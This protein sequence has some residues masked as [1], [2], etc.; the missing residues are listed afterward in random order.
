M[1]L[2]ILADPLDNQRA[3]VHVF[4]KELINAIIALGKADQLLLIREKIDENL[5]VE[6]IAIPN[7]HLP[8]GFASLRLFFI[9]PYILRKHKI[10]AVFEPAHFGPFNLPKKIKRITMI[11][12]LT[13]ILL[14][15]YHRWHSQILQRLFLKSILKN[16][17]WILTNSRHTQN[18]VQKVFPFAKGKTSYIHLGKH[19]SFKPT[20]QADRLKQLGI[21]SPY[22][23]Y[24]GTIEP[25]KNLLTLLKS[26]EIFCTDNKAVDLVIV[27]QLGWKS[28]AFKA[29]LKNHPF[30][31]RIHLTGFVAF[32][33]LPILYT[34]SIALIYPSEYEG[35]GLPIIEALA[36]G[37][38]VI[39]AHN[40]SLI[41]IGEE[42]AI[43][44]ET[45]NS[46][47]LCEKMLYAQD[48]NMKFSEKEFNKRIKHATKF[49]WNRCAEL[50][51]KKVS[52]IIN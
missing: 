25:R 8:I 7:I 38:Q 49:S 20:Q 9:V 26:F 14:P 24:V 28:E 37:T 10:D 15:Q 19:S 18:D 13:P 45:H 48:V 11:H 6:Q 1:K 12:D 50:F 39:A 47:D 52:E 16:T 32:S 34:H 17:D 42:A 29:A 3:G 5:K 30:R 23:M 35:F 51:L 43:F 40:S 41:E 22:F 44:F 2:A 21:H 46:K 36:C 31:D 4:T 27:G 33:D